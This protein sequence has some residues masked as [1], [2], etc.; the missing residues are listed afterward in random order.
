MS[1]FCSYFCSLTK[2]DVEIEYCIHTQ[3]FANNTDKITKNRQSL[4]SPPPI[5]RPFYGQKTPNHE[6]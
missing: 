5:V 6:I 4:E 1:I 2:Q 3:I